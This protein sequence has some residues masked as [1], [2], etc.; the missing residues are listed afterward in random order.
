MILKGKTQAQVDREKQIADW[1]M[2]ISD[3]KKDLAETDWVVVKLNEYRIV[4]SDD[5]DAML[6]KYKPILDARN[7]MRQDINAAEQN[8]KELEDATRTV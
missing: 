4:N 6:E 8:I 3:S 7:K 2:V 1:N 5:Y